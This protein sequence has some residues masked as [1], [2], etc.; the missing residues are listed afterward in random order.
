MAVVVPLIVTN[1]SQQ[2]NVSKKASR[3]GG[4]RR[5]WGIRGLVAMHSITKGDSVR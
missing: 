3:K 1:L 4:F 5:I 2:S